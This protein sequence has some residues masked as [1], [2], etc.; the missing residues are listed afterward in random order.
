[1]AA[2]SPVALYAVKQTKGQL[3]PLGST[4]DSAPYGWVVPT[5]ETDFAQALADAVKS[6]NAEGAYK[7]IL[8]KWGIDNGAITDFAVNP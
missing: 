6:L 7:P 1:M 8:A 3:A 5:A 4:Y 2:D